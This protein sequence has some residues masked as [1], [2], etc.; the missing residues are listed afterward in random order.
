MVAAFMA[1]HPDVVVDVLLTDRMVNPILDDV[2]IAVRLGQRLADSELKS[3]KLADLQ[4]VAVASPELAATLDE[5]EVVPS[6]VFTPEHG[7]AWRYQDGPALLQARLVV[8]DYLSVI[9]ALEAGVGVGVV[10]S[11]LAAEP[12]AAGRLVQVWPEWKLPKGKV[13]AVYPARG[14]VPLKIR[15]MLDALRE[16]FAVG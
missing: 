13:W 8:N 3:R 7:H 9:A 2:D 12:L 10:S 14:R 15:L 16:G 5:L 1:R 6:V 11:V 4:V